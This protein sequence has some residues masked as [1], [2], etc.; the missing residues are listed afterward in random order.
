VTEIGIWIVVVTETDL[1]GS[2]TDAAVLVTTV[3]AAGLAGAM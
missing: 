2:V 1:E 3:L